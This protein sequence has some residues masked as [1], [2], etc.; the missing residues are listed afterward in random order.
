MKTN[1]YTFKKAL[2]IWE[3]GTQT[4]MN[5]TLAFVTKIDGAKDYRLALAGASSFTVFVKNT[6][7]VD[8]ELYSALST[9]PEI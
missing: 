6:I 8:S 4:V 5:R 2:P 9:A 3:S 1:D 7:G